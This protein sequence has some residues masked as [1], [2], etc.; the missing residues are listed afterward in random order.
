VTKSRVEFIEPWCDFVPGQSSFFVD[1][2]KREL[3][4]DPRSARPLPGADEA[5][6]EAEDGRAFQV[7]LTFSQHT[8]ETPLPHFRAFPRLDVWVQQVMVPASEEYRR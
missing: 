3:C 1:E 5:F 8:E 6:F 4:P 7:H 2:H